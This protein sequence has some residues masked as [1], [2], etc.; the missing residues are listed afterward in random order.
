MLDNFNR[1]INYIRISVTDRCNL[2]CNYCMPA[3][4]ITLKKHEDIIS[5]ENIIKV[6]EAAVEVGITKVRLTGGE[7][8][9]RKDIISLVKGIKGVNGVKELAM[10]T[11]GVLLK[12]MADTLKEG[13]LDR[14]NISLDTLEPDKYKKLVKRETIEKVLEGIDSVIEA[15]FEN[16]KINMVLIPGFNENEVKNMK[17]FCLKKGLKLQRINHYSLSDINSIDRKYK[18]E[19]PLKC[20]K[21]NRI[22]LTADGKLKP[23]LFSDKEIELDL[24][25]IGGS[26]KRAVFGKPGSGSSNNSRGNWEI[27]G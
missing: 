6:V 7:P 1:E 27:G 13:G 25:D 11:N 22:R 14:I 24:S 15:G 26:L 17:K 10:T 19:R 5:Y 3:E 23:C 12:G 9:I 20:S 18:A 16:T 21:C 8:L 4:G 2:R